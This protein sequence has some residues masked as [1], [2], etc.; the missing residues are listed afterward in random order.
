M[1]LATVA[2]KKE[3]MSREVC[4]EGDSCWVRSRGSVFPD[5]MY[6]CVCVGGGRAELVP[7]PPFLPGGSD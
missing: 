5:S 3:T 4:F 2:S 6:L 7:P 1:F